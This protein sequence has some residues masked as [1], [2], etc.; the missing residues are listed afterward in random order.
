M[1]AAA[2]THFPEW[3]FLLCVAIY[4][5]LDWLF[6]VESVRHGHVKRAVIAALLASIVPIAVIAATWERMSLLHVI[7][8]YYLQSYAFLF[9]DLIF[10]P[11]A[12][13]MAAHGWGR[14]PR[15]MWWGRSR[16]WSFF[17]ALVG[18]AAGFYFRYKIEEP[19][20]QHAGAMGSFNAPAALF[21]DFCSYPVLFGGLFCVGI[22]LIV[23]GFKYKFSSRFGR[24][25]QVWGFALL[26]VLAIVLWFAVG[27]LH[28]AH[29]VPQN[30][31]PNWWRWPR[32]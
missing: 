30:L 28:D 25:Y 5:V 20:Y 32:V 22:P 29:L 26:M 24:P 3:A 4:A 12:A 13:A 7:T 18:L 27:I 14:L 9:G 6:L 21:H 15:V 8:H 31:H 17:S 16:W 19:G 11:F 23:K 1:A 10:L 2:S